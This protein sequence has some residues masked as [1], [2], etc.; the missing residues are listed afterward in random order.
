MATIKDI[1]KLVG[2]HPS[3]VS[4][5]IAGKGKVGQATRERVFAAMQELKYQPNMVARS[6]ASKSR[7]RI[8]GVVLP[9]SNENLFHNP[10][11]IQVLSSISIYAK[12][13]GY[14]VMH[15]NSREEEQEV[16]I[17]KDL[18]DSQWVD[19]IILTT[20]RDDDGCI[21]YLNKVNKPFVVIGKPTN[22]KGVLWVDNDNEK[23]MYNAT[24]RVIELGYK[25]VAFIG[26]SSE[27]RVN[28]ERLTGY[29]NAMHEAGLSVD[30]NMVYTGEDT[31]NTGETAMAEFLKSFIPDAIVTTDD[32][33]AYGACQYYYQVK[34]SYIPVIGFNNT[35]VSIYRNP[36]FST[37]D[38]HAQDLGKY[39][40]KLL[41]NQL[42]NTIT[43][44][45]YIIETALIERFV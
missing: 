10:F 12:S 43:Q 41:I 11:F 31:E 33:I 40:A 2:V 39:A 42:E 16:L 7:T 36:A 35:P 8:L 28:K 29:K 45:N 9:N 25:K 22:H 13:F 27:F 5:V 26:G 4:R 30:E 20:V 37:V 23:A 17:L 14:Y 44:K 24:K 38:I 32:L 21:E 19:G 15:V 1:A 34:E 18:V 3:T 6:L